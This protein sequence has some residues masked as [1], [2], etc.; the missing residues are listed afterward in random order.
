[1]GTLAIA[2]GVETAGELAILA[3]LGCDG[4]QGWHIARP[5]AARDATE[6]LRERLPL[7]IDIV[8]SDSVSVVS[9]LRAV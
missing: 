9:H 5:M 4:V 8:R 7:P 1:L 2:E 6:W 3:E